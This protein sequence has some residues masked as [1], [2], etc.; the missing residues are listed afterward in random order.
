MEYTKP[1]VGQCTDCG[2][3]L[4]YEDTQFWPWSDATTG[5]HVC[6]RDND[7]HAC[8]RL[9]TTVAEAAWAEFYRQT[10]QPPRH[11]VNHT[12]RYTE[13]N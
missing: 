13:G 4:R 8:H 5:S 3:D 2:T 1:V 9:K 7:T 6:P 11:D 12:Y 10:G